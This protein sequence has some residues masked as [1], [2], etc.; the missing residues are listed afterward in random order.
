[1]KFTEGGK[2]TISA[3]PSDTHTLIEV[4][5]TGVGM[6]DQQLS[7]LFQ[8]TQNQSTKGTSGEKGTGLGLQIVKQMVDSWTGEVYVKSRVGEGTTI[9]MKLPK[10]S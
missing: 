6:N 3:Q 10:V 7:K 1:M 2:I 9:Q 4:V 5:D 8:D